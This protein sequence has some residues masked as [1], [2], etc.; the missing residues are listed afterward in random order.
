MM[1]LY[2]ILLCDSNSKFDVD[3]SPIS[4]N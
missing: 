4:D 2:F 1:D 3:R